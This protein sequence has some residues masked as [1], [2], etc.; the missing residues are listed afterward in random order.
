MAKFILFIS[1]LLSKTEN[2][3][4]NSFNFDKTLTFRYKEM[5]F[6]YQHKTK[7]HSNSFFIYIMIH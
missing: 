1:E 5:I 6:V 4:S 7:L 2:I 3:Y